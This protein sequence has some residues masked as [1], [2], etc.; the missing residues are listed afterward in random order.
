[1]D[2]ETCRGN[3]P[4]VLLEVFRLNARHL[5]VPIAIGKH[6]LPSR[7]QKLSQSTV[8]ILQLKLWENSKVPNY[9]YNQP[10]GWFLLYEK[11]EIGFLIARGNQ[12]IAQAALSCKA[13]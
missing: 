4:L 5:S 12:K 8:T 11:T 13:V 1:M 2:V 9:A 10:K 6:L 7:T 3:W